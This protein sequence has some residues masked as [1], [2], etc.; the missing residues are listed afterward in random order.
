M[1]SGASFVLVAVWGLAGCQS[2][3]DDHPKVD[4]DYCADY[5]GVDEC[6]ADDDPCGLGVNQ[7]CE[8]D[9]CDW[10]RDDC[11]MS[12][13]FVD[14]CD[15][16]EAIHVGLYQVGANGYFD[17][18]EKEWESLDLEVY[19]EP[20]TIDIRCTEGEKVCYG[21]WSESSYWLWGCAQDCQQDCPDCCYYCDFQ[22]QIDLQLGC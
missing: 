15:D 22:G 20:G 18:G 16:T 4:V 1:R 7:Q 14:L 13:T 10:D 17:E 9:G 3:L 2:L 5:T 8:C 6:C 19:G 12:W 11:T 21:A